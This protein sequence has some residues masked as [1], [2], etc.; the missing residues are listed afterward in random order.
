VTVFGESAGAMSVGTLIGLPEAAGLFHR[1]ILQ[2]GASSNVSTA[3]RAAG[4]TRELIEILGIAA[5]ADPLSALR[6]MDID[7]LLDAHRALEERHPLGNGLVSQPVVDGVVLDRPPLDA[8]AAGSAATVPLL[9]GTNAD[10]WRLFA[11]IDPDSG[12]LGEDQLVA[13]V[14]R[15]GV[16]DPVAMIAT[17][18]RR[19]PEAQAADVFN[20]VMSDATFRM[21]AIRL[22][23]AQS[24]GGGRA[25][26]YLF[27]WTSPQ[28]DG[29]LGS[30]HALEIPFVFNTVDRPGASLFIGDDPPVGIAERM[31]TAWA[32]FARHGRP[33]GAGFGDWPAYTPGE[34]ATMVI[35]T[36]SHLDLDPLA[37][38]RRAWDTA[39]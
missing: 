38:E 36:E 30:C 29:A 5:T 31:N 8:V 13:R 21:P 17:Y 7:T 23:E 11:M 3:E 39:G 37:D 15:L 34:R 1:A 14:G 6:S 32:D 16:A 10:E 24:R 9:I 12:A 2:S 35:D 19:L 25:W 28:F 26:M 18:R 22:A 4:F 33:D 20:A 27:T